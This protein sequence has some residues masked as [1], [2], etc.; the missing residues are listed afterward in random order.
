MTS[1]SLETTIIKE[2]QAL[3]GFLVDFDQ[4]DDWVACA[5]RLEEVAN[6]IATFM[7]SVEQ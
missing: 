2:V 3:G 1:Q 7:K 6:T 4:D 5:K